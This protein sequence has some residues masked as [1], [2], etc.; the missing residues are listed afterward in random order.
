MNT[1]VTLHEADGRICNISIRNIAKMVMGTYPP[2][3]NIE[4]SLF[5]KME[6]LEI[7]IEKSKMWFSLQNLLKVRSS[8]VIL[9]Y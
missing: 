9:R 1:L 5:E 4:N 6:D 7:H 3:H 8:A 2:H